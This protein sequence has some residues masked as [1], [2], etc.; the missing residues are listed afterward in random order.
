MGTVMATLLMNVVCVAVMALLMVPVTVMATLLMN[1][2]YVAVMALLMEPVTVMAILRTSVV[3]VAV[4]GHPV[5]KLFL[6]RCSRP[7]DQEEKVVEVPLSL[8]LFRGRCWRAVEPVI[9][10]TLQRR[11]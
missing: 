1:V 9:T 6:I 4:M 11:P 3:Y 2:V 8:L 10:F 5:Q 7:A